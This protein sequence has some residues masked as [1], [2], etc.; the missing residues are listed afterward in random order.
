MGVGDALPSRAL[1][2]LALD[3]EVQGTR[4][5]ALETL[6]AESMRYLQS[7][8]EAAAALSAEDPI[9]LYVLRE[10]DVLERI[11]KA[12]PTWPR[13]LW[14]RRLGEQHRH[15]DAETFRRTELADLPDSVALLHQPLWQTQD[16]RAQ[17]IRAALPLVKAALERERTAEG[18][19]DVLER[20][21]APFR[22]GPRDE[23]LV[24]AF[25]RELN[26]IDT[27]GPLLDRD[28]V[29]AYYRGAL[30][31]GIRQAVEQLAEAYG[32]IAWYGVATAAGDWKEPERGFAEQRL[33]AWAAGRVKSLTSKD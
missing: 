6:M 28:V 32:A 15:D 29:G 20:V 1:A 13:L 14:L 30:Y 3:E 16:V 27:P 19:R 10:D 25:E 24:D 31:T 33:L 9:R 23:P 22:T 11:A 12:G 4:Q 18:H 21:L 2:A 7:A 8:R 26:E 17:S 5:P